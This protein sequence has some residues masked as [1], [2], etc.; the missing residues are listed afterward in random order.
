[1][2]KQSE[3]K[4]RTLRKRDDMSNKSSMG[5]PEAKRYAQDPALAAI[6]EVSNIYCLWM[7]ESYYTML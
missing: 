4:S 7:R 3:D 2:E 6:W 5:S 1:M